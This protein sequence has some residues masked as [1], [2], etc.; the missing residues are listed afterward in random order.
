M[1]E[2]LDQLPPEIRVHIKAIT[3]SAGLPDTDESF[4]KIAQGWVEKKKIFEEQIAESGMIEVDNLAADDE[5]GA[6]VLTYSG[7]LILI[8]PLV[9]G[10][11]K[12]GYNSIGIRKNVPDSLIKESSKLAADI[13]I[14]APIEFE[15][16]PVKSTS[17]IF[18]IAVC[19]EDLPVEDQETK[20][21]EV[22]VIM[23]SEF[24]DVNKALVPVD[25]E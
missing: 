17:S 21:S 8:G 1:G 19:K 2:T 22:T 20:I 3:Q 23:T 15:T 14:N 9:E 7:S 10:F 24:V 25:S 12:A 6:V 11:R 13:N 16:G 5:K 18:K 4:E